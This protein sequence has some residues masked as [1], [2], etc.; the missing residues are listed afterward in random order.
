MT[1]IDRKHFINKSALSD[2]DYFVSLIEQGRFCALLSDTDIEHVQLESLTQL[3]KQTELFNNGNSSSILI[4]KAQDILAS[5]L[6]TLGVQLK[7][8]VS[9]EDAIDALKTEG[10][11]YLYHTGLK[12]ISRKIIVAKQAHL[13]LKKCVFKTKNVF[14]RSTV[15]DGING[16][17]KLYNH[18]F[19][20]HEIHITADYPTF[21]G[22]EHDLAGIEF[23]EKYLQNIIFENKFCSYFSE[24][25]VH[26]LLCG[27]DENYQQILMNIYEPILIAS[28]GCILT[29]REVRSLNLTHNDIDTLEKLFFDKR[30]TVEIEQLLKNTL[31]KLIFE[32]SCPPILNDYLRNSISKITIPIKNAVQHNC[33]DKVFLISFHSQ[34]DQKIKISYGERMDD[35]AYTETLNDIMQCNCINDKAEIINNRISYFGDLLELFKDADLEQDE[36]LHIF[37]KIPFTVINELLDRYPNEDF[38]YDEDE[39]K[40]YHALQTFIKW[41][42]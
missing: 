34:D 16:F 2:K 12:K 24:S 25:A 11:D 42:P 39:L 19:S 21:N 38:L 37:Q 18:Q 6:F 20:A 29:N 32:L 23:I 3:A 31:D 1:N 4:E 41:L 10:L 22:E 26:R 15:V 14:Y 27:L 8:Y 40:I 7:S 35:R 9:P 28:L 30:T 13:K 5:I 33:L 36:L 17:F